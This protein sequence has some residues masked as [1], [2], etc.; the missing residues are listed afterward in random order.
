MLRPFNCRSVWPTFKLFGGPRT[1]SNG[2][3][4]SSVQTVSLELRLRFGRLLKNRL[5]TNDQILFA[6]PVRLRVKPV[7]AES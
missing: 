6:R 7:T 4:L 1:Y 5:L 2:W 3:G